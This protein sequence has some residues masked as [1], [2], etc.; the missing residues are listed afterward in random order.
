MRAGFIDQMY[1]VDLLK[2]FE[3]FDGDA[4]I[5]LLELSRFREHAGGFYFGLLF[6]WAAAFT[7]FERTPENDRFEGLAVVRSF[8]GGD[9][10]GRAVGGK[11]LE[12]L[13]ELSFG[14]LVIGLAAAGGDLF[15]T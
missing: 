8:L 12:D 10:V 2:D 9:R 11:R 7:K 4:A 6:T 3:F 14:V 5:E 1:S 15:P 13:L